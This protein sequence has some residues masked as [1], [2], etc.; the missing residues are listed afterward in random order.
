MF[1]EKIETFC[2]SLG[3]DSIGFTKCRKFEELREFYVY[4]KKNNLENEFEEKDIEKRINPNVYLEE[5]KTIISIAFP[6]CNSEDFNC[7]NGFSIYTKRYDYHRVVKKYLDEICKFIESLGGKAVGVVDSNSLPERYIAYLSDVGFIGKNNMIITK[8]HG[9][10]VF[11]GEII[12]DLEIENETKRTFDMIANYEECGECRICIGECPT[13]SINKTKI[14]PN[15]CLSYMTQ[16]KELN[17]KEINLLK[18]KGNIFGCDFCQLKCPYNENLEGKALKE[19]EILDYMNEEPYIYA[20]MDNKYFKEKISKT[21]C[22]WRGKNVIRR[23][24]IINLKKKGIDIE[25]FK[26]NSE[27]INEYIDKLK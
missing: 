13:K 23:N 16:K 4:R 26:G 12:T 1:K 10:Y 8:K 18:K 14:N 20:N 9:S 19:F 3:L 15:I 5:G 2:N 22:G 24:A 27:Y 7:N 17:D 6:Y 11:L 21:S 25:E